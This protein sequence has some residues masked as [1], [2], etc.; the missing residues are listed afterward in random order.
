MSLVH[1]AIGAGDLEVCLKLFTLGLEFCRLGL[2]RR[3]VSRLLSVVGLLFSL[4]FS[5]FS[6][7]S[8]MFVGKLM[9]LGQLTLAS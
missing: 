3:F 4:C 9:V 6:L 2:R 1:F 7:E 8:E 5:S